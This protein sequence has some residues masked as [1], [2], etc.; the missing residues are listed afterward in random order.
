MI[1][2]FPLHLAP[3]G[4]KRGHRRPL[5]W[6]PVGTLRRGAAWLQ[7]TDHPDAVLLKLLVCSSA[8]LGRKRLTSNTVLIFVM[9]LA[10]S[11]FSFR[12]S[13]RGLCRRMGKRRGRKTL[14][15]FCGFFSSACCFLSLASVIWYKMA[16]HILMAFDLT[17]MQSCL[18][19]A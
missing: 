1:S 16:S 15:S 10:A 4:R 6:C 9:G 5:A 2:F 12:A 13:K 19:T 11:S 3:L 7:L 8:A 17:S 14:P 18:M